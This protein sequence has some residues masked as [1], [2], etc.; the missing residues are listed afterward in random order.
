MG[1][2]MKVLQ[3][4]RPDRP[5][6]S[7]GYPAYERDWREEYLR[8]LLVN[9]VSDVFYAS[10]DMLAGRT[11]QLHDFAADE[12]PEFMARALVYARTEGLMRL[13]PL[14]GLA[15][16]SLASP[17]C[18]ARVFHRVVITIADLA[19]FT[20]ALGSLGRGQGGRM[21]KKLAAARLERLTEYE[22]LTYSG[23]GR[24]YSLRDLLRVYHPRPKTDSMQALFRHAAGKSG[25]EGP[26]PVL[27]P[28]IAAFERLKKTDAGRHP[29]EAARLI[30]E[31]R[32]PW[33]AVTGAVSEMTP[34]LWRALI[35]HMSLFS[36]LRQLSAL[37]GN[38]FEDEWRKKEE[39]LYGDGH[40][41][42]IFGHESG[43]EGKLEPEHVRVP[44]FT[45]DRPEPRIVERFCDPEEI[46]RAKILPF[47]FAQAWKKVRISWLR[48]AL[49]RAVDLSVDN[50]PEIPG[51]TAV[52]LDISSSMG[53]QPLLAGAVLA[54]SVLRKA[55][56]NSLIRLFNT[57]SY[58]FAPQPGESIL[59]AASRI[60]AGGDT[61]P[62]VS[63][64]ELIR[65]QIRCDNIVIV[66]DQQ[67]NRGD[68]FY[69]VLQAYRQ[70]IEPE[71]KAFVISVDPYIYGMIPAED[72]KTFYCY[73]WSDQAVSLIARSVR[74]YGGLVE[75]VR[76][77]E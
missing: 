2:A 51:K 23:E 59:A 15:V 65:R 41:E 77:L 72:D 46:R 1:H 58:P 67:Q 21:V 33:N 4:I 27:L 8:M 31:G 3:K 11:L 14:I 12:E 73:G 57:R 7:E 45:E 16:L 48:S 49:E 47:R 26:D 35:P 40:P 5:L 71:A 17:R 55:G 18:F 34:V 30:S 56:E 32:L 6:N 24:G 39:W 19:E 69:T 61:D 29:A 53:G 28:R 54:L 63:L 36:L 43:E 50:L 44:V 74:G 38:G 9:T 52:L 42:D 22:V 10:E 62:S 76:A 70:K 66:T 64:K 75:R 20:L 13:Q 60:T 37:S 68:E 25:P